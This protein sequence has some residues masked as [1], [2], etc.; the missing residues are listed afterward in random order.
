MGY[1]QLSIVFCVLS[2]I[3]AI[4]I[5]QNPLE[6]LPTQQLYQPQPQPK[7]PVREGER[8]CD[9]FYHG[10]V[11]PCLL[12]PWLPDYSY[13]TTEADNGEYRRKRRSNRVWRTVA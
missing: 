3:M 1:L 8:R 5:P 11:L 13:S 10:G 6:E 9:N 7:I 2:A 4:D 12:R